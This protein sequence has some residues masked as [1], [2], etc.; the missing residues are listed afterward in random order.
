MKLKKGTYYIGD[1]CYLF[2]KNWDNVL[3]ETEYFGKKDS[4]IY[5]LFGEQCC[6]GGTAYGDGCYTDGIRQYYV[7]AGILGVLPISLINIDKVETID[8]IN[9][10]EGMHIIE[11]EYDFDVHIENGIFKFGSIYIDTRGEE[12][13]DSNE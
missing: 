5:T 13:Y 2:N 12:D 8:S 4:P 6:V 10:S 11:F 9:N 3:N 1:P 7:D